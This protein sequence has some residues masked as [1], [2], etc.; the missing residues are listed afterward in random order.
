MAVSEKTLAERK[1]V[2]A[3][4]DASLAQRL[5]VA[6]ASHGVPMRVMIEEALMTHLDN[7]K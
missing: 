6:A 1:A 4:L 5:K 3:H 7:A 2:I